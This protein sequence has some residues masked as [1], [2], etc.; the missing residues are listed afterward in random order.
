M[1][2][3][4][5]LFLVRAFGSDNET[6]VIEL[7]ILWNE[8]LAL[9]L[10]SLSQTWSDCSWYVLVDIFRR[11]KTSLAWQRLSKRNSLFLNLNCLLDVKIIIGIILAHIVVW[12]ISIWTRLICL[13][14]RI[15]ESLLVKSTLLRFTSETTTILKRILLLMETTRETSLW[16]TSHT[17]HIVRSWWIWKFWATLSSIYTTFSPSTAWST[18]APFIVI[19]LGWLAGASMSPWSWSWMGSSHFVYLEL[20]EYDC[21]FFILIN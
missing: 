4:F 5:K 2:L 19:L 14:S 13:K 17:A 6:N 8:H 10:C 15:Y 3:L 16:S 18:C 21:C 12:E 1:R 11:I 7:P 9:N 20:L